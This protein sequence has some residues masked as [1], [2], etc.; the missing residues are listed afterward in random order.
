M[1]AKATYRIWIDWDNDGGLFAGNF[2]RT[3]DGWGGQG[4]SIP[5]VELSAA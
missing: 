5:D 1:T 4:T 2:E 3:L